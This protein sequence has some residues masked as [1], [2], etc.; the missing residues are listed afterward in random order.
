MG[1]K[2][3]KKPKR[4]KKKEPEKEVLFFWAYLGSNLWPISTIFAE[5]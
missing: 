2:K 4:A 1:P 3:A 5:I